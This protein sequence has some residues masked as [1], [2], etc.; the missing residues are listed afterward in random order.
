MKLQILVATMNQ[1]DFSLIKKMNI[2][3]DV[4]FA[5]QNGTNEYHE[6]T[7][8]TCKAKMISTNTK[9]V[10]INRNLAII[11]SDAEILLFSDDD[12][13][14]SDDYAQRVIKEFETNKKA[15]VIFF[16][17]DLTRYG[18]KIDTFRNKSKRLH[19]WNS[20]KYGTPAMAVRREFI[21]KWN[22]KFT[23]LYGGGALYSCG[24]DSLFILDLFRKGAKV[25]ASGYVLGQCMCDK[26]TW[27]TGYHEKFFYD[28][29]AWLAAAFP[30]SK[31]FMKWYFILRFQKKTDL[32][33]L[34]AY[35]YINS[36]IRGFDI[37]KG[38]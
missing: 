35:K 37:L 22:I 21:Q 17:I 11:Y 5:N 29:G 26:S 3:T 27:F 10:G 9:G 31:C 19:V 24:E 16:C 1:K 6:Y 4:V 13:T 33:L 23:E 34:D 12:I 32:S 7:F 36:G 38:Y 28:K 20:L 15:D 18:K 8:G 14:Y 30:K 25:Y 2:L